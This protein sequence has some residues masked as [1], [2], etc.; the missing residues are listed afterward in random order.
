MRKQLLI[1]LIFI[2]TINIYGQ[3]SFEKGYF[4]NN[5]GKKT[6]CLIKNI[7]WKDNPIDFKYKLLENGKIE[8]ATIE[9]VQE[10]GIYNKSKY[11][12]FKVNIDLSSKNITDLT[13]V[14]KAVFVEKTLFLKVLVEGKANLY[15]HDNNNL[16]T[17]LFKTETSDIEQLVY[18]RYKTDDNRVGYTKEYQ[19]QLWLNL[20]CSSIPINLIKNTTY[21]KNELINLFVKYNE[22]ENSEFTNYEKKDLF[23]FTIRPGIRSSSLS[24]TNNSSELRSLDFGNTLSFQAG[25]ELEFIMPFN[26]NKWALILEPTIQ[27]FKPEITSNIGTI[28]FVVEEKVIADY[29][30]IEIPIGFRHY[31]YLNKDSNFFINASYVLDFNTSSKIDFQTQNDEE[32]RQSN[33]LALVISIKTNI[34]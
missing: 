24:M 18:K 26:N 15:F 32:I 10:F 8:N 21:H 29:K 7:D 12:R 2:S 20:K 11:N 16:I 4:I 28:D 6:E 19:Q 31:F 25:F 22:C 30:S 17:F 1:L 23:N 34:A 27:S 3:T 14:K 33:Y 13:T 5:T 9:S